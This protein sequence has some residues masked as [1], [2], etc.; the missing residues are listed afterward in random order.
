[1]KYIINSERLRS[2]AY[3]YR[4]LNV[5]LY[6][7][8]KVNF[9]EQLITLIDSIVSGYEVDSISHLELL[10]NKFGISPKRIL[11]SYPLKKTDEIQR[12][13][14]LGVTRFVIDNFEEVEF[15][16]NTSNDVMLSILVRIS[17]ADF[18]Q[19]GSDYLFK[20]G[21]SINEANR[22]IDVIRKRHRFEGVS[23]YLPQEV[24][25][26]ENFQRVLNAINQ[27]AFVKD[28]GVIDVGGGI[29]PNTLSALLPIIHSTIGGSP[30]V[31]IEPGLHFVGPCIE[32]IT[33]VLAIREYG[34]FRAVF[35]DTGIYN[36]LIDAVI[37][38]KHFEIYPDGYN[39]DNT[40]ICEYVVC[41]RSS[42]VSDFLGHYYLP[43]DLKKGDT[44]HIT[45]CGAYCSEMETHF[46]KEQSLIYEVI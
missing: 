20:W 43:A 42:D 3:A 40:S 19:D 32:M 4:A 8:T 7:P 22:I 38:K 37:K 11:Y 12:A 26:L 33:E 14:A 35:L 10:I 9:E 15:V 21:V 29:T 28:I 31:I 41:G 23:F 2:K 25:T 16:V 44:L 30:R 13:I 5:D 46:Y 34:K 24:N 1:M 27:T 6:Y 45:E 18:V 39:S 36:G 17:I